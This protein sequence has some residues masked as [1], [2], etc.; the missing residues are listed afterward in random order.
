MVEETFS[1]SEPANAPQEHGTHVG[2]GCYVSSTVHNKRY[3]GVLIE[4]AALKSASLLHF[5]DEAGSLDLNR[6]MKQLNDAQVTQKEAQETGERK[7]PAD[8]TTDA[9]CEKR[10]KIDPQ[11]APPEN[12]PTEPVVAEPASPKLVATEPRTVQKFRYVDGP[13]CYRILLATYAN[14]EAASEDDTE[15][16]QRIVQACQSGGA[17]VGKDYYQYEVMTNAL[18]TSKLNKPTDVGMRMSLGFETFLKCTELPTW[19]PLCNLQTEQAKVLSILNMSKDNKGNVVW[20]GHTASQGTGTQIPMKPRNR[21]RVGI[22]GAGI[23]G[24]SCATELLVQAERENVDL[25]VVLLEGRS[26]VGGRLLTDETTFKCDDGVTPFHVDLGAS[27]IHGIDHNPLAALAKEA[28]VTF[29]TSSEE[30]KML[31]KNM[32]SVDTV[33]DERIGDLFDELLDK[34]AEDCWDQEDFVPDNLRSQHAVRWYA[35][36]LGPGSKNGAQLTTALATDA[37]PHRWSSD[38]SIDYSIG[39]AIAKDKESEFAKMSKVE[40]SLLLWN[41]KNVEYALG[42]NITDLSMMFW[43]SDD[44]HAF[45]GDHVLLKEGYSQIVRHM[46]KRLNAKGDR[47]QLVEN[48]PVSKVEYARRST[49][50]PYTNNDNHRRKMVELSDTC[51]VT[52]RDGN[53]SFHFDFVV[54]AL[55]L[56][57][58]KD[59]IESEPSSESR[60]SFEP[61]LPFSK[62]DSISNVGFGLL[63]KVYLQF[64][65]AFWRVPSVLPDGQIL[66]GNASGV[67]PEHYMFFDVGKSL[68]PDNTSP[69]IL[70]TLISGKE[71]VQ[72]E[73]LSDDALVKEVLRTL[74]TLF[75]EDIVPEPLASKATRWGAD[76]FSR[77]CYTFLPPGASDQD[78]SILQSPINGNGD[79]LVLEGSETMRL[80]WAGEHTTSLHPSMAHGAMLSGIRAAKE[81]ISTMQFRHLGTDSSF[82]KLLPLAIYRGNNPTA[83]LQCSMCHLS[84]SRAR[85]GSLLA[86]QRGARQVLAH[87]NCAA[88]TPEVEVED[89]KWKN[90]IKSI[91]RGKQIN[92]SLCNRDGATV[93]CGHPNCFR[94]YHFSCG[95]DT[96]WRFER[97]GKE[98]YCDLHRSRLKY[99]ECDRVSLQFFQSKYAF[100]PL[101]C[102]LCGVVGDDKR[103]G[104]LLAFQE[105]KRHILIHDGCAR[106]TTLIETLEEDDGVGDS[107][108]NI[109]QCVALS[110]SCNTCS[111]EGATIGCAEAGCGSH[112]HL[113]CATDSGWD[114]RKKGN[115]KFRCETHRGRSRSKSKTA[116]SM[117]ATN[118]VDYASAKNVVNSASAVNVAHS[119]PAANGV[120][121]APATNG[122]D[123]A[124]ATSGSIFQHNLFHGGGETILGDTKESATRS[125]PPRTDAPSNAETNGNISMMALRENGAPVQSA[126]DNDA[127]DT[128]S[129]SASSDDESLDDEEA[130]PLCADA[131][132][133]GN[134]TEQSIV[135]V[136]RNSSDDP[137][138]VGFSIVPGK[139]PGKNGLCIEGGEDGK[140]PEGLEDGDIVVAINGVRLGS[141]GCANV[142][143][144][145]NEWRY[146]TSV[147]ISV[148]RVA[149]KETALASPSLEG[150]TRMETAMASPS[151]EGET[152]KEAAVAS[153][154]LGGE[155]RT[156]MAVASPS[157][158]GETGTEMAVASP[159][160]EGETRK[161]A[162][163][164]SASLVEGET[165][166]ETT[167]APPSLEGETSSQ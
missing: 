102:C 57:V 126:A 138:N 34:A 146:N 156:E 87:N 61:S 101:E 136:Q 107:F 105:G 147:K 23:A 7:R 19:F 1:L 76:E 98:F 66:F 140:L 72:S 52:A 77:G 51:C 18:E 95:E 158:G 15:K 16:A 37:P 29:V 30:V 120:D 135:V 148:R 42:A 125:R 33:V 74:R 44:R 2:D 8:T 82:D 111:L 75:S 79:S 80:F 130:Q 164:A 88:N 26:R 103:T 112:F 117:P 59:S 97:D 65:T 84:G 27:W 144:V 106:F 10:A 92:C 54:S 113:T 56:G 38:V 127:G 162:A 83:A 159:S 63:N 100:T 133:T 49:T 129:E 157:L 55:P 31:T 32:E 128:T 110:T 151:L 21:Y 5:R 104:S 161:E 9:G 115:K 53:Q 22:I 108:G 58:L 94:S 96:G 70:M 46:L 28:G 17:F 123:S 122:V 141:P 167:V 143:K 89:G 163:V 114:F 40:Q 35:S 93:G 62:R 124:P 20:D 69:A 39:K 45:E 155:T 165:R 160:L 166:M 64:P 150:E 81:V 85:E 149:R 60:V 36:V 73:H 71:A 24:L 67:N 12:F 13:P 91:N 152:R 90:V 153:L 131:L 116:D 121:G 99:S 47:F 48:C 118:G 6:R 3:Y 137:W 142:W 154:S 109:S 4:Q 145:M 119:A 134:E 139:C 41:T 25:E 78:F 86:F 11:D 14:V 43:D 68:I 50:L 132:L